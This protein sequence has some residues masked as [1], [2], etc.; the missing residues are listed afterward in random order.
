HRIAIVVP[1]GPVADISET[2]P[3]FWR[4]FFE[5]LRRLGDV[6]GQNLTVE[7]YS[8]EGRPEGFDDLAREVV[9]RNPDV[10][11]ALSNAIARAARAANGTM[12]MVWMGGD[13]IEAGFA[14]SLAR[15][16]GNITG[17]TVEEGDEIWGKRLQILKEAVPSASKAA[18]LTM[19]TSSGRPEQLLR[20]AGQRL[21][22]SVI[23]M[24]LQVLIA[25]EFQH[26]FG[27]I[28]QLRPDAV[29]VTSMGDLLPYRQLI[30]E[31]VEKSRLPAM[32]PWREYVDEGG[33]MAYAVDLSELARHIADDVHEI[34]N[35]TKPGDIPIYQPAKFQFLI[36]LKAA[37]AL[38]LTIPPSLL[39]TADE[40]VE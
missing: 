13:P 4:A 18:F 36:N 14:T 1:A 34:L 3:A 19:R 20:E 35:G 27:K 11:V 33:L 23:D 10:T 15:P 12:P 32:Y 31:L 28:A 2:G 39:A 21:Q 9:K 22:I 5:E 7:R 38:G 17:V 8:G 6:E 29:I 24:P 37:K 25:A 16:G 30:I 26:V 40:V